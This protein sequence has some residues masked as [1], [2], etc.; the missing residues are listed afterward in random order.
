MPMFPRPLLRI[1][2]ATIAVLFGLCTAVLPAQGPARR[3]AAVP[4][5][6][7]AR[8][9]LSGDG[10]NRHHERAEL[11]GALPGETALVGMSLVLKPTEA[12][13]AALSQ[14][15]LDQANPA[16]PSYRQ[17]LTPEQFGARFGVADADLTILENWLQSRGFA[18]NAVAGSRNRI[19][20]S[21]TASAVEGAFGVRM[22]RYRRGSQTFYENANAVQMPASLAAVVGG[23]TGLSSYRLPA[24]QQQ[25]VAAVPQAA[26]AAPA[27]TSSSGNHYIVPWDFRQIF[28]INTLI[29]SGFNGTGIK[30]GVIG[31]SAVD[32]TQ[33]TY[34]QQKTGQTVSLPTMVLVPNTSASA[35][36]PG[37]EEES[38]LDLE[39]AGGSAPGASVQ[40][41][42]TGCAN[43]TTGNCNNNG[44]FDALSYAITSNLAPILT[45]SYGG[46]EAEDA[47][48]AN[49]TVEP[50]LRQSNAQ[51][52][53]I[54]VSSGDTGA[55]GCETSAAPK[56]AIAGLAVSYPASSAYV[57]AVGGT[58][59][60]S[61]SSTY[62][63][64]TN[65]SSLGSATGYIP[66]VA[67]NDTASYGSLSSSGGGFSK[68]FSKPSWQAGTGVPS[69]GHR[70]VPDVAFPASVTEH[71]YLICDAYAPCT[72]GSQSFTLS[73][74]GRDGGAVGGTS[75]SA[76]TFAGMVAVIEQANGGKALGNLNPSLYALAEGPSAGTIFHDIT[77]GSNIVAC[78]AGTPDCTTGSMGYTATTGYDL[79]TGLGSIS[80]P[81]LRSALAG[82][83]GSTARIQLAVST[84]VPA[85]GAPVTFTT[86]VSGSGATPGGTVTYSVDGVVVGSAAVASGVATYT[87]AGFPNTGAHTLSAAYSGDTAYAAGSASLVVNPVL[88]ASSIALTYLPANPSLN[89]PVSFSVQVS[90][91]S[92]T[93]SGLVN[94]L[95]DGNV[96][97]GNLTNGAATLVY[98]FKT[99]GLHT[100]EASYF[101]SATYQTSSAFVTVTL[102]SPTQ[103]LTPTVQVTA[104]PSSFSAGASS[105]LTVQVNGT[106]VT[107][108]GAI[109]FTFDGGT[110]T[111]APSYLTNGSTVTPYAGS[112]ITGTH[113]VGVSYSGD[114]T[115]LPATA[116]IVV[117]VLGPGIG[118]ALSPTTLT[119]TYSGSATTTA[120]LSSL[121]NYSGQVKFGLSLV[122]FTGA[123]FS[124][125]YQLTPGTVNPAPNGTAITAIALYPA[126]ASCTGA[127]S[128]RFAG[129]SLVNA[130]QAKNSQPGIPV[131]SRIVLALAGLA[132]LFAFRGRMK[133]SAALLVLLLSAAL[134]FG[135]CGSGQGMSSTTGSGTGS[136]GGTGSTTTGSYVIRV[137]ATSVANSAIT[138]SSTLT[139]SVP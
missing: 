12:Q 129:T 103:T 94:L 136:T 90:G 4:A 3:L 134:G 97:N 126:A 116:S 96:I 34:F 132:G 30:I 138:A 17:W 86:T 137:T 73:S 72:S 127:A 71:A 45:L 21:G 81:D 11:Q 133:R 112:T 27:Y 42:Y 7:E 102:T 76:P 6:T 31:Q 74:T 99:A 85:V 22:Q 139:L 118:I 33:L 64:S 88:A 128:L 8:V 9:A 105:L 39:Y 75:A 93:P 108:T 51:G 23:V 98:T 120:T 63:S 10:G 95:V 104:N 61:D 68:I 36:V 2:P 5:A 92:G 106:G 48:Y 89:S 111:P 26:A 65:N 40:F 37:D 44:V 29:S 130:E 117:T 52:Q 58:Q 121:N 79:V 43:A 101:G 131:R 35:K 53:T 25:R 16:S 66:E 80:A 82:Y 46:C 107:P 69:D 50:L 32:P 14:L 110:S 100:V 115:Y 123:T 47:S 78:T 19:T 113:V 13:D 67:W 59:L 77:S 49:S 60:N 91:T 54:L 1:L 84:T 119:S 109:V 62:W 124:G 114:N 56:T 28:G 24:P 87:Y 15:L 122:S 41:I 83:A 18:V 57:T 55:A 38:E 135:G 20:F 70:D 125:C